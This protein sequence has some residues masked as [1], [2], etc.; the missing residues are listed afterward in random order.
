MN[1]LP[2]VRQND[3][4]A[5]QVSELHPKRR[6]LHQVH[7]YA[8]LISDFVGGARWWTQLVIPTLVDV[9]NSL[10]Q[11]SDTIYT[12]YRL[13]KDTEA[14]LKVI[15]AELRS[16]IAILNGWEREKHPI[17]RQADTN[18]AKRLAARAHKGLH[19]QRNLDTGHPAY[20]HEIGTYKHRR[21]R[22]A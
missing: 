15:L 16:A 20:R 3:W 19:S 8:L 6:A 2:P 12:K 9:V 13:N 5:L 21:E 22:L 7:T 17:I 10:H 1:Y 4:P 14:T 18:Y 11:L